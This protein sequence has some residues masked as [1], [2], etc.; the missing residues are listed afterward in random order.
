MQKHQK[1]KQKKIL[2]T[3]GHAATTSL[4]VVEELKR[5]KNA[6]EN[7]EIHWIGPKSAMEG[8]NVP[9][10]AL[11]TLPK[12]GVK[13]HTIIAG[14]IQRKL[15]KWSIIS[16]F[17][18]PLGFLHALILLLQIKPNIILSFGGYAGFPVVVVGWLFRV[19]VLLHDQT[20]SFNR[21]NKL[22]KSFATKIAISRDKSRKYYPSNKTVLTGNPIMS[23]ITKIPFKTTISKT[24]TVYVTGGS[25]GALAINSF[26][27]EILEKLL[28]SYF[29]VHQTGYLDYDNFIALR[30][31]LPQR[32]SSK[33]KIYKSIEPMTVGKIY[34]NADIIVS[35][36]GANTVSEIIALK[37]PAILIPLEIGRWDEQV[38]NAIY[39]KK[40]GIAKLLRQSDT[41]GESLFKEIKDTVRNWHQIVEKVRHK[42]SP[43]LDA[44]KKLVDLIEKLLD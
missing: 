27:E 18:F 5:R 14:R 39:A 42:K 21:A 35:R 38:K 2:L 22:S 37:R 26:I 33:Y 25:S 16:L 43:D 15:T 17:K 20:Y 32:L 4:A 44:S 23:Q 24:P 1:N 13:C 9:T 8:K 29:V 7:W 11:S 12:K 30:G 10:L 34:K 36:A 6:S 3:G 40:V 31:D 41:T 19:P 28:S